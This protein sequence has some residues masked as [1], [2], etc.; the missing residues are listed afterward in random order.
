MRNSDAKW[1]EAVRSDPL[2][3]NGVP[4]I[5]EFRQNHWH[6]PTKYG[7][8]SRAF[9]DGFPKMIQYIVLGLR[10]S[11]S[12][13]CSSPFHS[14]WHSAIWAIAINDEEWL[15]YAIKHADNP[16][17]RHGPHPPYYAEINKLFFAVL[18]KKEISIE[19]ASKIA[20]RKSLPSS[21]AVVAK[22]LFALITND[23]QLAIESLS[24]H[25]MSCRKIR[26]I[27][28][29]YK[30]YNVMTHGLYE[31]ARDQYPKLVVEWDVNKGMPWDKELFAWRRAGH[32]ATSVFDSFTET[33]RSFLKMRTPSK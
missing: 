31:L 26:F 9:G 5:S 11:W 28:P 33:D 24:I 12:E 21:A 19:S 15:D 32:K 8:A 4:S 22:F 25:L 27:D 17:A 10:V 1:I 13:Y 16:N 23:S 7:I 6:D 18:D 14:L 3:Q 2:Y 29:A 20:N 30:M